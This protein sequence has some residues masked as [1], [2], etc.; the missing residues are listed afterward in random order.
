MINPNRLDVGRAAL[1]VIDVQ[2]KLLPLIQ[3]RAELLAACAL[4]VRGAALFELPV[5]VTEQ[6]PQGIGPTDAALRKALQNTGAAFVTK[7]AFSA[8][9]EDAVRAKM[10]GMDRDQIILC[11]IESHVCVQQTALDLLLM[12]YTTVVC[13]DAIGSRRTLDHT[14][15]LERMRHAGAAVTTVESVLFELCGGCGGG[16]FKSMIELIKSPRDRSAS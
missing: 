9:G 15:A 11:G 2:E 4:L 1:L 8:C 3:G 10:R 5:V 7:A 13:A 14:T 6:Y 16:R 12:D